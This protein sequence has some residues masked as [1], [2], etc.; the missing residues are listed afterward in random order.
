MLIIEKK[1][2]GM[3]SVFAPMVEEIEVVQHLEQLV[4]RLCSDAETLE[5]TKKCSLPHNNSW[6]DGLFYAAINIGLT[7]RAAIHSPSRT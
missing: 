7:C 3:A 6:M 5:E 2:P 4:A 1:F